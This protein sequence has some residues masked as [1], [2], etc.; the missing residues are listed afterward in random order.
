MEDMD[1]VVVPR[2]RQV[3]VNPLTRTLRHPSRNEPAGDRR[4]ALAAA[5][6][7]ERADEYG[8]DSVARGKCAK[9]NCKQV[10][11]GRGVVMST[12]L[13]SGEF[14]YEVQE[15]W[16]SCPDGMT[17]KEV[18]A[19]GVDKA[20]NVYCFTRGGAPVIVL[21][22]DGRFLR[23]WGEGVFNPGPR[24]HHGP[25]RYHFPD[26]R[27][28]PHGPQVHP[29]RQ[30]ADDPGGSGQGRGLSGGRAL[31][32]L[33]PR[34]LLAAGRDLC[35]GR[36][37]QLAGGTS[38]RRTASCCFRGASPA[39]IR[40]SS[41]LST[42]SARTGTAGLRRRPGKPP[43]PGVRRQ[44]PVRDPVVRQPAPSVRAVHGEQGQR[45]RSRLLH[46][47]VG[48]RDLPERRLSE[49][50]G[51]ASSSATARASSL[52]ASA[53]PSWGRG[54]ASSSRPTASAWIPTG[55]CT[56]PKCPG[57]S[58][59]GGWNTAG[60]AE[61]AEAGEAGLTVALRPGARIGRGRGR[62]RN[63]PL[64]DRRP[65]VPTPGQPAP[66]ASCGCSSSCATGG[67]IRQMASP[68]TRA[69]APPMR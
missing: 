65:A 5:F 18:A 4:G 38:I 21:D 9:R 49:P 59:D 34:G 31:Q 24:R 35:L 68:T 52:R 41:T 56:W 39:P 62:V 19:V 25:G 7:N 27:R 13:G 22:E 14:R 26:R 32:P 20:D 58:W 17:F 30:G 55:T 67:R 50:S 61:P 23:T 2:T 48:P 1:L 28:R 15:G 3:I 69:P 16:G 44:G 57:P 51:T 8:V 40:A 45:R 54:R 10:T 42:T 12:I 29:R 37:R 11:G 46:R 33:H 53:I 63:P 43:H 60:D 47:R 64:H 66:A 36:L 6:Q